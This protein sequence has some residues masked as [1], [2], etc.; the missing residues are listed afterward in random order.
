M[1][2]IRKTF[3][4]LCLFGL[5]VF[6]QGQ[7]SG[8]IQQP[9]FQWR[10]ETGDTMLNFNPATTSILYFDSIPYAKDYTLIVVYKP[11]SDTESTVWHLLY[12]DSVTRS[13]TTERILSGNTAIRYADSTGSRPAI[14]TLRQ[15]APE[16]D[17]SYIQMTLGDGNLMMAE[18]LYFD[19]RLGN[20]T[21]RRIQTALAVRY[22]ITL[23][24]VDYI[25]SDG[26]RIWEYDCDSTCY[27]HHVTGVGFDTVYGVRQLRSH[28]EMEGGM[29]TIATD[30]LSP[31]SFLLTGDD[32]APLAYTTV[33]DGF[34]GG[35][36]EILSRIWRIRATGTEDNLFSLSF[37]TRMLPLPTDSLVLFVDDDL[38]LPSAITADAVEFNSVF[39]PTDTCQFTLARGAALWRASQSHDAHAPNIG[40]QYGDTQRMNGHAALNLYPNP[41]T[42]R[43]SLE[44]SGAKWVKATVYNQQ[45]KVMAT[46]SDSGKEK[47]LFEGALP[48]GNAYYATVTTDEGDQTIK[49]VVK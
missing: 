20:A 31:G 2:T 22:G 27:H 1:R 26:K 4:A 17:T 25:S 7:S 49:I 13:L 47:Y 23:G 28:S 44:V 16:S 8:N 11:V 6:A 43:F 14:H 35:E 21:L 38:Y 24:P 37:D 15:S 12:G 18:M 40:V 42:E 34:Y 33:D 9:T 10:C 30:T 48:S 29:V 5:C 41:T 36:Y 32:D 39:F 19:R 46:Y 45:G 3:F